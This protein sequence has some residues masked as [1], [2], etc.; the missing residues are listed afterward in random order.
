M[1]SSGSFFKSKLTNYYGSVFGTSH[2]NMK[3]SDKKLTFY[4]DVDGLTV[5]GSEPLF[6]ISAMVELT[7][8]QKF[9]FG[10]RKP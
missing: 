2:L 3:Y 10:K 4:N 8:L 7:A 9:S 5:L 6:W 1:S